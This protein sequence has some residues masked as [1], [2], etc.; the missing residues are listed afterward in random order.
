[1]SRSG[2]A[3]GVCSS[4][5]DRRRHDPDR[6]WAVPRVEARG[7]SLAREARDTAA[8]AGSG[9]AVTATPDLARGVRDTAAQSGSAAVAVR[10]HTA[11]AVR[12]GARAA[13]TAESIRPARASDVAGLLALMAPQ[14][15][16][17]NLLPRNR[18]DILARLGEFLV[19]ESGADGSSRRR[20]ILGV[21]A[22]HHYG[23]GLAEV[24]SL[25]I[26]PGHEG[27]GLGRRLLAALLARARK[28]GVRRLIALT[29]APGFFERSGFD[30]SS[31]EAL[32]EKVA[33][34]CLF[35]PKRTACD[36]IAMVL[37]L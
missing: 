4:R 19:L 32:P 29:R 11:R 6:H 8:L 16:A 18:Q 21:V 3:P 20:E 31:L 2:T 24:R 25:T 17:G 5:D 27:R 13:R 12:P 30:R 7:R 26:A 28:E 14:I 10:F 22:L 33:R 37:P 1:M 23:S 35:C 34:D 36:E 15:A 9:S